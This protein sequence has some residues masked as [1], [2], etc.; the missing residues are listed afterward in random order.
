MFHSSSE[1]YQVAFKEISSH[2][3]KAGYLI[4]QGQKQ[5]S[6]KKRYFVL[7]NSILYYFK[8]NQ[9]NSKSLGGIFLLGDPLFYLASRG[10]I[11]CKKTPSVKFESPTRTLFAYSTLSTEDIEEWINVFNKVTQE[12]Y[13]FM[14]DDE[15]EEVEIT[16]EILIN[17]QNEIVRL[18]KELNNY[19][20]EKFGVEDMSNVPKHQI[21]YHKEL[22]KLLAEMK[23]TIRKL[24]IA[25]K[26]FE[27]NLTEEVRMVIMN[28]DVHQEISKNV[29]DIEKCVIGNRN[30]IEER[31]TFEI[32]EEDSST[33]NVSST[34]E[35]KRRDGSVTPDPRPIVSPVN[36][37]FPYSPLIT[38]SKMRKNR[39]LNS[40]DS[41]QE[42]MFEK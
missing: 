15:E 28:L 41:L 22:E 35:I 40:L 37:R 26:K 5:K 3:H 8:D 17:L 27:H 39:S 4:K 21:V 36:E 2:I 18:K 19:F 7:T 16:K 20:Y 30:D 14:D 38:P 34:V 10:D 6:W 13:E 29:E 31:M 11:E 12:K 23:R 9:P 42:D 24:T 1:E 32:D 25:L 33:S